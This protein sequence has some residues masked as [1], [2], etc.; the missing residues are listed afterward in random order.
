VVG[1]SVHTVRELVSPGEI[2]IPN[3][4]RA[5]PSLTKIRFD[6]DRGAPEVPGPHPRIHPAKVAV[7]LRNNA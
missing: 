5:T 1:D 7:V 6:D 4:A 3:A 2:R